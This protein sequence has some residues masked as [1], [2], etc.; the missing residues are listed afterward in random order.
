[1]VKGLVANLLAYPEIGQVTVTCNIPESLTL[2]SDSRILLLNNAIPAG[3]ATNHNAA[4]R[5]SFLPY[6]CPLNPDVQFWSNP[7]PRLLDALQEADAT[8][9]TPLV[10]S[11]KG[12]I[13]DSI[14]SFPTLWSL[15]SKALKRP[16]DDFKIE[17]FQTSFYSD[18]VAGMFML[19]R[20]EDFEKLGGFDDGF[21][22]YYEDVDI[23]ARCWKA[24]MKVL[25]CPSVSIIH[26]ARRAS[27]HNLRYMCWHL[28]SMVRY[29]YKYWGRL[30]NSGGSTRIQAKSQPQKTEHSP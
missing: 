10:K 14:R 11:P 7:F 30:P 5:H 23:C 1:M 24:G 4:F 17:N 20:S 9:V 28:A 19:F 12:E 21:F 18:W 29:F 16:N 2:P 15:L 6:F 27:R 3:F 13:E 25:A 8:I 22:L 26:D